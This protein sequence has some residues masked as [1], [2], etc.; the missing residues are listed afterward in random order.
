MS[1]SIPPLDEILGL[2]LDA[3]SALILRTRVRKNLVNAYRWW[4]SLEG[5]KFS[6]SSPILPSYGY[7][8]TPYDKLHVLIS[9]LLNTHR[10]AASWGYKSAHYRLMRTLGRNVLRPHE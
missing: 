8:T 2:P 1:R 5:L 4:V 9:K 7:V 6:F 10:M 3:P